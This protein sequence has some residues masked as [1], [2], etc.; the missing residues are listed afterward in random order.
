MLTA[1]FAVDDLPKL[2]G[3]LLRDGCR[4]PLMLWRG[5]LV[6][7]H[8]RYEIRTRRNLPYQ[9]RELDVKDRDAAMLWMLENQGGRRNLADIDRIAIARKREVIIARK[10][11]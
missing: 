9:T 2:E 7:G 11:G 10:E 4:E 8:N 1:P 3:N 6:D 5:T